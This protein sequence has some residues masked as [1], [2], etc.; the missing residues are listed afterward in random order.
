MRAALVEQLRLGDHVCW[1]FDDDDERLAA[2]ARLVAVG[3][4]D[5]HKV[6]YLTGAMRPDALLDNLDARGVPTERAVD[7]GQLSVR[8]AD[9]VYLPD[10]EF[11]PDTTLGALREQII[12]ARDEGWKGLRLVEDMAWAVRL[13]PGAEQLT[14]YE[15][16]ANR[17][18]IDG[19]AMAV[20]Q[21]DRRLFP[22]A[23]LRRVASA[24]AAAALAGATA[25][26]RPALRIRR[27]HEPQGLALSGEA[28]ISNR[29]ALGAVL[30]AL[31]DDVPDP[32]QPIVIDLA[33]LT[34]AD[35]ATAGLLVRAALVSKA[36]M[37]L[38]GCTPT[39]GRLLGIL[40]AEHVP[41]L[42]IERRGSETA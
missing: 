35:S 4:H 7:E 17:L 34:F 13:E 30:G 40:G 3:I 15:A 8:P 21:Y 11:D 10:G 27:T 18:V 12:L 2:M 6:L 19:S 1:T 24:H 25:D 42:T 32:H 29:Q 22:D 14:R 37:R 23:E 16:H 39:V 28:D 9:E 31:L 41:G 36:G 20:C 5:S 38:V 26:W 33:G